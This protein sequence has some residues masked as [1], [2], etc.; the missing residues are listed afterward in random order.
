[1]R[2]FS[3]IYPYWGFQKSTADDLDR[4]I[5][6][7]L[8]RLNPTDT[9]TI[10][11]AM[12]QVDADQQWG[13]WGAGPSMAPGNKN[14]WS[15]EQGGWVVNS[16]GFAGPGQRYT[17]AVMNSLGLE[18]SVLRYDES[19]GPLGTYVACCTVTRPVEDA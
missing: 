19:A 9:A 16:V 6:Y 11:A 7:T 15:V 12:Q 1:M 17:L 13:V 8:T 18:V 4:L 3:D 14:G 10:V 2:G 5:N